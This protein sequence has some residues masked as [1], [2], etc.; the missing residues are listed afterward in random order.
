[1]RQL[2]KVEI[3]KCVK[4]LAVQGFTVVEA[5]LSEE[6]FMFF[7]DITLKIHDSCKD[8]FYPGYS[9][10]RPDNETVFNLPAKDKRYLDLLTDSSV[11][12]ILT[13]CLNDPYYTAIPNDQPNYILGELIS[14]TSG[15]A[16]RLHIDSWIPNT[17]NQCWMMQIVFALDDRTIEDG[18]TVVVPG[19]H[20]SGCYTDREFEE[21]LPL[22]ASAGDMIIWDSRLWHGTKPCVSERKSPVII[23]TMQMWWVKQRFDIP[24][25]LPIEIMDSLN[26]KE[27]ALI[28]LCSIPPNDELIYTDT[29]QGY[30]IL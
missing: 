18:C 29:R 24:N 23:A 6:E 8:N 1:V 27:K 5:M 25:S 17:G 4:E 11:E 14:R 3:A 21:N 19:S 30:D 2:G 26:K 28:G 12:S 9:D 16:L 15:A 22:P 7:R 10:R 13:K 20:L